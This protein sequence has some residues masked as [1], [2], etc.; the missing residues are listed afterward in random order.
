MKLGARNIGTVHPLGGYYSFNLYHMQPAFY[1]V[2][3]G[4]CLSAFSFMIEVLY[5]RVLSK[6]S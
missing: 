5:K 1:L 3:M 6:K 2:L 4:W